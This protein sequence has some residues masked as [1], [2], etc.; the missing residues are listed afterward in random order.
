[1]RHSF[2]DWFMFVALL[3]CIMGVCLLIGLLASSSFESGA[4]A[5]ALWTA[6]ACVICGALSAWLGFMIAD[7]E[8]DN[9]RAW[10][11]GI[12]LAGAIVTALP[13]ASF[14]L[15]GHEIAAYQRE[16]APKAQAYALANFGDFDRDNSGLITDDELATAASSLPSAEGRQYAQFLRDEQSLAGHVIG[17][18]D[19]TTYVWI[20]TGNGGGYMSPVTTTTYIYG[21]TRD[22]LS[23][24]T[25]RTNERYKRW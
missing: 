21:I 10:T 6:L 22:D 8:F 16:M 9:V 20:S 23:G 24:F 11:I 19:T 14:S 13:S 4:E 7:M 1:M 17:S 12:G 3:A 15:Q 5:M 18:Y 25:A 2:F